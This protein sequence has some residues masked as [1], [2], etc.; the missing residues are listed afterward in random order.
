[1]RAL[2]RAALIVT[3]T[4]GLVLFVGGITVVYT[5]PPPGPAP[6]VLVPIVVGAVLAAGSIA[7][8]LELEARR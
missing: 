7:A 2:A 6:G 8:L 1:M 3:E 4:T 5:A